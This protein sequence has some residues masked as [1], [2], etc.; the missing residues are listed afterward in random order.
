[1]ELLPKIPTAKAPAERFSGDVWV[2]MLAQGVPP[3][4]LVAAEVRFA[5]CSRTAWHRHAL[6]Q[7][8]H[9]TAGRG[10]VATRDGSVIV[11]RPGDTVHTPPGEWH[12]HG[13]APDHFMAHIAISESGGDPAVADVDWVEH[14]TDDEYRTAATSL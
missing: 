8:L 7:T 13:A 1:M 6:G 5:P 2:D 11:L 9:V 4:R 3:S 10:L 12:W 14:V